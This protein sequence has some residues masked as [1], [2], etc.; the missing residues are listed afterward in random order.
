MSDSNHKCRAD[1]VAEKIVDKLYDAKMG[2]LETHK[3]LLDALRNTPDKA[4]SLIFQTYQKRMRMEYPEPLGVSMDS[5]GGPHEGVVTPIYNAVGEAY[6][7]LSK[8]NKIDAL[9]SILEIMDHMRYDIV[10][11]YHV[12]YIREPLLFADIVLVRWLYWPG[13]VPG[14]KPLKVEPNPPIYIDDEKAYEKYVLLPDVFKSFQELK[15]NVLSP[16][17][18]MFDRKFTTSDF[19]TAYCSMR[20]DSFTTTVSGENA[21]AEYVAFLSRKNPN[22]LNRVLQAIVA[23]RIYEQSE[24]NKAAGMKRLKELLPNF[25]G[26]HLDKIAGELSENLDY[27]GSCRNPLI[28]SSTI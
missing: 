6:P 12:S 25:L 3:P 4:I 11:R 7:F 24:E 1:K 22:F 15:E 20:V 10:Q 2:S 14:I 8:Q 23:L 13:L 21:Q 9:R 18:G 19:L 16:D 28:K 26:D 27:L 5:I 17:N